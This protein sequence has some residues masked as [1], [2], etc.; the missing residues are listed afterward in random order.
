MKQ[1]S[2]WPIGIVSIL[3]LFVVANLIVMRLANDDPAFA[4]EPDYYNKAVAFDST[5]AVERRSAAL[6]WSASARI[7][8]GDSG[9]MVMV[10]L[11]D[12]RHQPIAGASVT[13]NARFNARANDVLAATLREGAP[14]Q[15]VAPLAVRHAGQWEV[16][17]NAVRG[18][19]HF[20]AST[21]TEAPVPR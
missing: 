17:I 7:A 18:A 6:A 16:R 13:I 14:G 8:H 21:R 5:M 15:Y 2:G 10:T 12:A 11:A 3:V 9:P 19:E 1:G 20:V 4:I